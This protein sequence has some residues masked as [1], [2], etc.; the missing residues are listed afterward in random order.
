MVT[1]S[2]VG[3]Y[4]FEAWDLRTK[5]GWMH[6]GPGVRSAAHM[7]DLVKWMAERMI[8]SGERVGTLLW[9]AEWV[10]AAATVAPAV[11]GETPEEEDH[12]LPRVREG[13]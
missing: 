6:S 4:H 3:Q 8:A 7:Q 5:Y 2:T 12:R 9:G 1:R 13:R 11:I 10:G